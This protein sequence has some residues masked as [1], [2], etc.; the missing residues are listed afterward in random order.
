MVERL[1]TT[2]PEQLVQLKIDRRG[3]GEVIVA[4]KSLG[5]IVNGIKIESEVGKTPKVQLN[6]AAGVHMDL[7][8]AEITFRD[9]EGKELVRIA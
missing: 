6:L 4:G 9:S 5:H 2:D 3:L 8:M 7:S 1:D